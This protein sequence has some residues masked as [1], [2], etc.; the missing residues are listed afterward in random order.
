MFRHEF[1]IEFW[2]GLQL[3]E[4]HCQFSASEWL[5]FEIPPCFDPGEEVRIMVA[6]TVFG[7]P[8]WTFPHFGTFLVTKG[9]ANG[10]EV[11]LVLEP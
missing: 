10:E 9:E 5:V 1:Y 6:E 3:R 7:C 8:S 11:A 2:V 4:T